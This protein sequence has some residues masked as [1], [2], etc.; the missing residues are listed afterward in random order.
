MIYAAKGLLRLVILMLF[1]QSVAAEHI[2]SGKVRFDGWRNNVAIEETITPFDSYRFYFF[3]GKGDFLR[4]RL[5][6]YSDAVYMNLYA[7]GHKHANEAIFV[8]FKDGSVI[9]GSLPTT[10]TYTVQVYMMRNASHLDEEENFTL[11]MSLEKE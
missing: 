6:T 4:V 8:G 2:H 10:G 9:K 7:P 3:A 11:Y 1:S 5:S